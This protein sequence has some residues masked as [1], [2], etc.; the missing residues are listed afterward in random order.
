LTSRPRECKKARAFGPR[1]R[2]EK[3]NGQGNLMAVTAKN[4]HLA[5]PLTASIS[6]NNVH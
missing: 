4:N 1:R 2:F 5:E 6:A 3:K